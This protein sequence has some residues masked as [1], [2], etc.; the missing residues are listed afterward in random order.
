MRK[1]RVLLLAGAAVAS[2]RLVALLRADQ[3]SWELLATSD[4]YKI[5]MWRAPRWV[6]LARWVG[7]FV[8]CT[9]PARDWSYRIGWGEKDDQGL[10]DRSLGGVLIHL[11]NQLDELGQTKSIHLLDLPVGIETATTL[12]PAWVEEIESMRGLSDDDEDDQGV[13]GNSG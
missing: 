9:H 1:R 8:P 6:P 13:T 3:R 7:E 10:Y 2:H 5:S 11:C 4:G 12:S